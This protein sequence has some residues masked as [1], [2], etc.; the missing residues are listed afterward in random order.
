MSQSHQHCCLNS[1]NHDIYTGMC[2]A[3]SAECIIHMC[4]HN[5]KT[6]QK[7]FFHRH[8]LTCSLANEISMNII[9][10]SG[11]VS[12]SNLEENCHLNVPLLKILDYQHHILSFTGIIYYFM[13]LS[14]ILL[15]VDDGTTG[16]HL[17][18]SVG[19]GVLAFDIRP[20]VSPQ[21]CYSCVCL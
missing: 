6:D 18:S 21:L 7:G 10:V 12:F 20:D 17:W 14:I 5:L 9:H 15:Q 19:M 4:M 13:L 1:T 16:L 11:S 3:A 2:I 8:L